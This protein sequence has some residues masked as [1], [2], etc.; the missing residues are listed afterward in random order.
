YTY[1]GGAVPSDGMYKRAFKELRGQLPSLESYVYQE[2]SRERVLPW[3]HLLGPLPVG[4]LIEHLEASQ[5]AIA[6]P[7]PTVPE[8]A[9]PVA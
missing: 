6:K 4:K 9:V 7:T 3:Q 1:S 2:W 5:H 8:M